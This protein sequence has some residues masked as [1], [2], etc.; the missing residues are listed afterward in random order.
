MED[1]TVFALICMTLIFTIIILV[2]ITRAKKGAEQE[3]I[4]S[5]G[6]FSDV[7][8]VKKRT[9]EAEK[10]LKIEESRQV[11]LAYHPTEYTYTGVTVGNVTTGGI[12]K[13][14][15]HY[16]A[17]LGGKTGGIYLAYIRY[18]SNVDPKQNKMIEHLGW[19]ELPDDLL[20][21]ARKDKILEPLISKEIARDKQLDIRRISRKT[22]EYIIS[23]LKG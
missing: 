15:A 2:N 12:S 5:K 13:T 16:T 1:S 21:I 3:Q 8:Q 23:W 7:L 4:F 18:S 11:N 19:I 6:T 10:Y 22:A 9:P 14:D 17:S 20:E